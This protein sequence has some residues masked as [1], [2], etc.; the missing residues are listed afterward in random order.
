MKSVSCL[1]ARRAAKVVLFLIFLGGFLLSLAHAALPAAVPGQIDFPLA[2]KTKWINHLHQEMGE[3]AHFGPMFAKFA[4]GN[5]L[6]V[7]VITEVVGSDLINGDKYIRR[8]TRVKGTLWLTEWLRQTPNGLLLGKS[9][10]AEQDQEVLMEP[11]E[12]LL[13]PTLKAGESWDWKSVDGSVAMQ[14][15]VVGPAD[16][17]VPAGTFHTSQVSYDA[18]YEIEGG[19]ITVRQ[20]SWFAPGVGY[21]KQETETRLGDRMLNHVVMTLEKY[22]PG[23]G[24][25]PAGG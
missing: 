13:S 9:S 18:K 12:K 25:Q 1:P 3:G 11:P 6:D 19:V 23:Q 5:T 8:E 20:T 4:K 15:K 14:I 21:V 22:E 10:D 17:T 2:P 16:L 7:S 24:A